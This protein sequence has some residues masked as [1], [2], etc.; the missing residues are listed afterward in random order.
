M[1]PKILSVLSLKWNKAPDFDFGAKIS[2]LG[3]LIFLFIAFAK[4]AVH[5]M[6]LFD[7]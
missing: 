3:C 5:K 6:L 7:N 1:T 2:F 4:L